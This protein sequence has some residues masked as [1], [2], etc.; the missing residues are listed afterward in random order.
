MVVERS[1]AG[2]V[3]LDE[4]LDITAEVVKQMDAGAK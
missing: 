4:T 2:I 1:Q 3:F